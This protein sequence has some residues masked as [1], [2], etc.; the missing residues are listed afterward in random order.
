M[1]YFAEGN[2]AT[3]YEIDPHVFRKADLQRQ[4]T[5]LNDKSF[6]KLYY[7]FTIARL[8]FEDNIIKVDGATCY[9]PGKN[10]SFFRRVLFYSSLAFTGYQHV[11]YSRKAPVDDKH[12]VFGKHARHGPLEHSKISTCSCEDCTKHRKIHEQVQPLFADTV[13]RLGTAGLRVPKDDVSDWCV[14]INDRGEPVIIFFELDGFDAGLVEEH[15]R[16]LRDHN[17]KYTFTAGLLAR[18]KYHFCKN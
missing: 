18:Y 16:S 6:L 1:K 17:P 9:K 11:L 10:A 7:E 5:D 13:R 12:R 14:T 15:L 4:H 2:Q 3:V 8:L